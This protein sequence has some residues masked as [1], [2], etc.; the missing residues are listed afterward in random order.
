[1]NFTIYPA[2]DL[3]QGKVVRLRQ[4]DPQALT[5]YGEN[6]AEIARRW[7]ELGARW[8]HVVNLDGAFGAE[9]QEN[10]RALESILQIARSFGAG[11]QLGGGLRSLQAI[12][13][14]WRLGL[15]RVV[16]GT[17]AAEQPQ[18]LEEAIRRYGSEAIAVAIDLK[19]GRLRLHG[20][21]SSA[22]QTPIELAVETMRR[23][24]RY[25]IVTDTVRDGLLSGLNL[26]ALAPFLA[27]PGGQVIASG[28]ARSLEDLHQAYRA[29]CQG[30][31]LGRSLYE[32]KIDLREALHVGKTDHPL[33]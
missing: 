5:L 18:A 1:M 19:Q 24:A 20:W 17:L 10:L 3:L 16:L 29:G 30:V 15:Q 11:V 31:I 25:L 6:P 23:G 12:E 33:S 13:E 28:G 8:L 9:G 27:L 2:L 32:G 7:L 14:A 26:E 22:A 21:R 4:G